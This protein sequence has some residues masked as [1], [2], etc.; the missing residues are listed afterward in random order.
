MKTSKDHTI[1]QLVKQIEEEMKWGKSENW[2]GEEF[3]Q[4]SEAILN[5]TGKSISV[6]T[7]KRVFGRVRQES[8][9]S[10]TTLN[11]LA[12]FIGYENW[13]QFSETFKQDRNISSGSKWIKIAISMI[14]GLSVIGLIIFQLSKRFNLSEKTQRENVVIKTLD[15]Q[16]EK[17]ENDLPATVFTSLDPVEMSKFK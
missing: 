13:N 12:S 3:D 1:K 11:I 9:P 6:T 17:S 2:S 16:I 8:A 5:S 14:L 15:F 10:K 7:L 4:L